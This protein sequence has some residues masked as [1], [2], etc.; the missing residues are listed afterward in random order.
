MVIDCKKGWLNF[1][2]IIIRP[3]M[4][5][6]ELIRNISKEDI[7]T[8]EISETINV[9]LKPFK[10]GNYI[11]LIRLYFCGENHQLKYM[12]IA[13][14]EKD[15]NMTWENW[16]NNKEI[17]RKKRNEKWLMSEIDRINCQCEWGTIRSVYNSLEGSS[18]IIV[19]Y[20]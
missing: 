13:T 9:L 7:W 15:E 5:Y 10:F 2:K 18:Y 12:H 6:V 16:D 1:D 20:N 8:C 4:L 17:E 3:R 19:Q 11:F 14:L